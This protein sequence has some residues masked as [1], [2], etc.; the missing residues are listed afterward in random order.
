MSVDE[1]QHVLRSIS[2]K[3]QQNLDE[4]TTIAGT[5]VRGVSI[6]ILLSRVGL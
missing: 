6:C 1:N 4:Y 5:C 2:D 3:V